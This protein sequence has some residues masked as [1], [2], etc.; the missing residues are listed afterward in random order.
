MRRIVY[1]FQLEPTGL[2]CHR[3]GQQHRYPAANELTYGQKLSESKSF[4]L[5]ER[6][7]TKRTKEQAVPKHSE[8]PVYPYYL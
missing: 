7:L 1:V 4:Y 2:H 8:P 5:L 6:A 3:V